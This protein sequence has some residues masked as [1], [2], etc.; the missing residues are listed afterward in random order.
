MDNTLN[1][2]SPLQAS[3]TPN[4]NSPIPLPNPT[5]DNKT[6]SSLNA[7]V[8]TP[9]EPLKPSKDFTSL[10]KTIAIIALS[11]TSLTFIGLFIW[12]FIQ[13]NDASTDL[14]GQISL[15]VAE[16][17]D[18]QAADLEADFLEREKNP[19]NNFSGPEDYG[20]LSFKY[21]KTWSVYVA[22][23]ASKGG[24]FEAFF[25][26]REVE[27]IS[28]TTVNSL[29]VAVLDKGFDDVAAEYQKAIDKKNSTLKVE[30]VTVG[31]VTATRYTGTIPKTELNGII[32]IFK[33]RDKT[34]VLRTDSL[35]FSKD[36]DALLKTVTFNL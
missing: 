6:I 23:D 22:H 31:G 12:M 28:D 30:S 9:P 33:I 25:N 17:K 26:P 35:L 2:T 20:Q 36:F 27:P 15:A 1:S 5:Q 19:F 8:S 7:L 13:Y 32:V 4:T 24:K 14:E 11:L 10:L 3:S 29:R 16:A 18:E 21:P 34:V